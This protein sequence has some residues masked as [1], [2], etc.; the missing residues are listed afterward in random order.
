MKLK[1]FLNE[2][3]QAWRCTFTWMGQNVIDNELVYGED[4][5]TVLNRCIS[6]MKRLYVSKPFSHL[7]KFYKDNPD[8]YIIKKIIKNTKTKI[9]SKEQGRLL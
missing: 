6:K 3:N 9:S 5:R 7:I 8:K 1:N 2:E 4:E